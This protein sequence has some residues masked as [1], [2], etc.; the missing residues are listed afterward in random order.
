M[1]HLAAATS[2]TISAIASAPGGAARGI[3][4]VSG[5]EALSAVEKCFTATDGEK[6]TSRR[7]ATAV[8]GEFHFEAFSGPLPCS[9]YVWPGVR[10]YTRE[11]LVEIH[12]FGSPPLLHE[13]LQTLTRAGVRLAQ[14]GEFTLRAFLAGR[15]DLTQAEAVLG[16]IDAH[17]ERQLQSALSQLAGGVSGPLQALRSQLLDALAHLEAGLDFVEEDIEFITSAELL[18]QLGAGRRLVDELVGQM[19]SRTSAT[20]AARV[21]LYG[22]PNVGKS[23]LLNALAGEA[24]AI[25][26]PVAG[27]TRDYVVRRANIGGIDCELVDTAGV[28]LLDETASIAARAQSM[29]GEQTR[30]AEIR[31]LCLDASRPLNAWE[32]SQVAES[33]DG[34]RLIVFTKSDLQF[35]SSPV[36]P[37]IFTSSISRAG[38]DDLRSAI[39]A[40]ISRQ[41][42]ESQSVVANTA[43]RCRE[44]LAHAGSFLQ[45]AAT[46]VDCGAGEE[47]VAA[48]LRAALDELGRVVGAIYTDDILDRVFS[49]FCIGK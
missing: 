38:I 10:S 18:A 31:I 16:V 45:H 26:S 32:Q 49:R 44:S 33:V 30:D 1:T 36:S 34:D 20:S 48:E 43:A 28:E 47:L 9:V 25:V 21:V 35:A 12:T 42:A 14:P 15:L 4:R 41:A 40:S 22:W 3:V 39:A 23:S 29:T 37:P 24:A 27:T 6:L 19:E 7:V 11:P 2:E 8:A 5:S 17:G 46:L 13:I